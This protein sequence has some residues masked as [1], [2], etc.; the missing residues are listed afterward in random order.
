MTPRLLWLLFVVHLGAVHLLACRS[1]GEFV[2]VKDVPA[3]NAAP[4]DYRIR[5]IDT[6]TVRVYNQDALST[7]ERVRPDGRISVPF[8]GEVEARGRRPSELAKELEGK[9][10]GIIVAPIVSVSV[11]QSAQISVSVVGEVRN[12]GTFAMDPGASVLHALAS[13]GGLT[14]YASDDSIYVL[15]R[16]ADKRVRFTYRELRDGD[17][18]AM[19]F[20]LRAG[21]LIVVE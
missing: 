8:A 13:A 20:A 4:T 18:H 1:A 6:V 5:D 16:S 2:W 7:R 14:E 15:R 11:E 19:G 21:D 17:S 3:S 12:P 10:K 9:L